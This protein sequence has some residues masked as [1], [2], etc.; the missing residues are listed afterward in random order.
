MSE[1]SLSNSILG[2]VVS[3]LCPPQIQ[4]HVPF[5]VELVMSYVQ[6][7]FKSTFVSS[8]G[9]YVDKLEQ[10][11]C[12]YTG[13]KHAIAV[14]NGTAALH[15]SLLLSGVSTNDEVLVPGLTFVATANAITYCVEY[16]TLSILNKIL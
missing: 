13:A 8:V 3:V 14:V 11:I 5:F 15:I 2:A 16:L 1:K 7:S 4:L 12:D 10:N 6:D 9:K